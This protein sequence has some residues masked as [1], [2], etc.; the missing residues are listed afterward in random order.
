MTR[1]FIAFAAVV[2]GCGGIAVWAAQAD[3]AT[4]LSHVMKLAGL[5]DNS[6][7]LP[8]KKQTGA[9]VRSVR[10][11][12]PEAV[13]GA[14]TLTLSGRTAPAEEALLSSRASGI[15]SERRVDIGDQVKAGD[16]LVIIEAPEIEQEL[17]RARAAAD[18]VRARLL[19]ADATLQRGESLVDKG[20]V[21]VQTVDERRATKSAAEADLAA[22]LAEVKRLEEVQSF[23]TVRAPF[24]GTIIARH[25]ERGDK[26]LADSS[27]PGGYLLR[28]A[29]LNELRI[30]IDIPQSSA[31]VVKQGQRA[32]VIFAELPQPRSARI[33]RVSGQIDQL[34]ST[35]RAE[36]LM[37]NADNRIPAG[38]NGQ[39]AIEVDQGGGLVTVPTNTLTTR[40]GQQMVAIVDG[41]SRVTFRSVSVTRDLGER[42]VIALGL[43]VKDRVIVSPNALLRPGDVVK[44]METPLRAAANSK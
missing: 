33:V 32:K 12:M 5:G 35:M 13:P 11:V 9:V 40:N 3:G 44:V 28:I 22:A 10:I 14:A 16:V 7:P 6:V 8:E 36:L 18:Q 31:L 42:V 20:H 1:K 15:V 4:A 41:E 37:E 25:I 21:S 38:M 29:R 19:L 2:A 24:D 43:T 17:R 34:S 30:L 26:V 23:Q 39:V 27:Q